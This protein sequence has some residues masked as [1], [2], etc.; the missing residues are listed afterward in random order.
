CLESH[1]E[2]RVNSSNQLPTRVIQV[3]SETRPPRLVETLTGTIESSQYIALSYCWGLSQTLTTTKATYSDRL[4]AIPWGDI[5]KTI[6][7]AIEFTQHLGVPYIWIDAVCII[8]DDNA[9]WEREAATMQNVYENALFTLSAT[10]S[11]DTVTGCFLP[12]TPT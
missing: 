8:Q 1:V 3:G 4:K 5:P 7:E 10:S 11:P 2:C 6:Q 9:D 12:R